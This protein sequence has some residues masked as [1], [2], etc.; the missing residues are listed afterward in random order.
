MLKRQLYPEIPLVQRTLCWSTH[1]GQGTS[2]LFWLLSV[3]LDVGFCKPTIKNMINLKKTTFANRQ[4]NTKLSTAV[5]LPEA[6]ATCLGPICLPPLH[7]IKRNSFTPVKRME[8]GR[9]GSTTSLILNMT[10]KV[11][12]EN[13]QSRL[14]VFQ[15]RSIRAISEEVQFCEQQ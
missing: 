8:E 4:W 11:N 13:S 3:H 6:A 14:K 9:E 12:A 10:R 15:T 1:F 7:P 5:S 2:S